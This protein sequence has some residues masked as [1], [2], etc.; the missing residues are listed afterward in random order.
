MKTKKKIRKLGS[1]SVAKTQKI[2]G[3]RKPVRIGKLPCDPL[4]LR[5]IVFSSR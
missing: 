5:T 1:L 4:G 3:S 2:L